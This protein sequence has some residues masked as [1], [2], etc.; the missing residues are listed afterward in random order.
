MAK[1]KQKD[2]LTRLA[3]AGE[4][5]FQLVAS[6]PGADRVLGSALGVMHNMRDQLDALSKRVRG[7]EDLEERVAKLERDVAKLSRAPASAS[8]ARTSTGSRSKASSRSK[9]ARSGSTQ[10]KS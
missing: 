9:S 4:E 3:D 2:L 7:I 10:K 8:S 1:R 6:A 5:A